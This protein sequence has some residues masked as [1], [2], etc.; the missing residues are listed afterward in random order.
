[1]AFQGNLKD[2]LVS[3]GATLA[4]LILLSVYSFALIWERWR[5]FKN[6]LA[7]MDAFLMKVRKGLREDNLAQTLTAGRS[8]KGLATSVV[9]A[10]LVGSANRQ[11]R[12][13]QADRA[14]D[15]A[16]A[17]LE[18]KLNTIATIASTAPFIGLFGTVIGV[19]RAF[20]DL[21]GAANSG[22]GIVAIGI[23]EALVCTATG[24][25]VAIPAVWAYN[26]FT[27]RAEKFSDE[28]N[29]ISEE[30]IEHLSEKAAA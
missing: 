4:F 10:S 28:M 29:W 14:T 25:L 7:G 5:F 26:Y 30:I 23:S 6:S 24:L 27:H 20:H 22:P 18:E 3:G 21:A 12:K 1:M 8:Y 2:I 17:S 19:I 13:R 11:E 16:V 9:T 15:Q